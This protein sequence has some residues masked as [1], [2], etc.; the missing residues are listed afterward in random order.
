MKRTN[1]FVVPPRS[2]QDRELLLVYGC[3]CGLARAYCPTSQATPETSLETGPS[4]RR[5]RN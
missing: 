4:L 2:E 5:S 1:Q 3:V